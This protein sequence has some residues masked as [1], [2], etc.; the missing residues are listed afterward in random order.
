MTQGSSDPTDRLGSST[1]RLYHKP[2][3]VLQHLYGLDIFWHVRRFVLA[4]LWINQLWKQIIIKTTFCLIRTHF[5]PAFC[6]WISILCWMPAGRSSSWG[7]ASLSKSV[8]SWFFSS[9]RAEEFGQNYVRSAATSVDKLE[10][11]PHFSYNFCVEC[12][13]FKDK[14]ST[15]STQNYVRNDGE[16]SNLSTLVAADLTYLE[17]DLA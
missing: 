2:F 13:E 15:H 5:K 4:S 8:R 1:E 3:M 17:L 6:L 7:I 14:N 12:V 10:N 11:S 9:H 16:F